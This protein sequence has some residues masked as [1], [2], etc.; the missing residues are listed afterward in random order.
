MVPV[1]GFVDRNMM[2]CWT[3]ELILV[4]SPPNLYRTLKGLCRSMWV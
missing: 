2:F 4:K 3:W 1:Q